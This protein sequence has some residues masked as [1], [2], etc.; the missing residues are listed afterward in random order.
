MSFWFDE[1]SRSQ[2]LDALK[3]IA[4]DSL[5]TAASSIVNN[6]SHNATIVS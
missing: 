4:T 6:S 3:E 5:T 2:L 1:Q